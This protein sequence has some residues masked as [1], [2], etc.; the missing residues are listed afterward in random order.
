MIHEHKMV[1]PIGIVCGIIIVTCYNGRQAEEGSV[2][3]V[4]W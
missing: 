4:I 3:H 1:L 2:L